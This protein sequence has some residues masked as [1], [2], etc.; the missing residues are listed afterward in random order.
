MRK[1]KRNEFGGFLSNSFIQICLIIWATVELFPILWLF[2]SSFK[3]PGEIRKV[4]ALPTSL[5]TGNYDFDKFR[6]GG[7]TIGIYLRNSAI[8]ASLSLLI[9]T[10]VVLLAAYGIAKLKVTGK[11][12]II[13][14]LLGLV[15]VPV[16]SL[17][18]PI[19]YFFNKLNMLDNIWGLV[20][21]YVAFHAPFSTLILQSYFKQFPDELIEAAK[22]D[23]CSNIRAFFTVVLP[24]SLGAV[25]AVTIL[26]F[27]YIW[28]EFLFALVMM[29]HNASKTLPV[30]LMNFKGQYLIEWGPMMAGLVVAII[31]TTIFYFIFHRNLIKGISVGAVKG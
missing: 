26:N 1:F 13:I 5:Y 11:N 31:P 25:S 16:H 15:G 27:T 18:I 2:M 3:P 6:E 7:I 12:V 29:R 21:P 10:I 14:L 30:G 20:L 19:F 23:G 28:N 4:F 8:V 17:M 9:L 22:I 24:V